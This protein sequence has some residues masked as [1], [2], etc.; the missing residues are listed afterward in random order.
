[1]EGC[2]QRQIALNECR[3]C[4]IQRDFSRGL[5]VRFSSDFPQELEDKIDPETWTN[6]INNLNAKYE[7]AEEVSCGSVVE[8]TISF[9]TCHVAR[10]CYPTVWSR[11]L[12]QVATF[13]EE[14]NR[15]V[16]IPNNIFVRDPVVKG[17]R[18]IEV[19]ILDEFSAPPTSAANESSC[20][21]PM[22]TPRD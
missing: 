19:S 8:S 2:V 22:L 14:R 9:L 3:K 21:T 11:V 13:I 10:L 1:M 7:R 4:Y 18:V 20:I 17:L 12:K 15:V 6:F 16:F 5:E